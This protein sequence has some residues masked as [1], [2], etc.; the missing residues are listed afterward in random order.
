MASFKTINKLEKE[1]NERK[2]AKL[3]ERRQGLA[4]TLASEFEW[5]QKR[6][7]A[8]LANEKAEYQNRF[9][10]YYQDPDNEF[11]S[12]YLKKKSAEEK[13]LQQEKYE[14][15]KSILDEL[16]EHNSTKENI[17]NSLYGIT[18]NNPDRDS[19]NTRSKLEVMSQYKKMVKTFRYAIKSLE[20]EE[21]E[22]ARVVSRLQGMLQDKFVLTQNVEKVQ[23]SLTLVKNLSLMEND[24]KNPKSMANHFEDTM[25]KIQL[26][27]DKENVAKNL[28]LSEMEANLTRLQNERTE[29]L[30]HVIEIKIQVEDLSEELHRLMFINAKYDQE[31]DKFEGVVRHQRYL[32]EDAK[33][34]IYLSQYVDHKLNKLVTVNN[35]NIQPE[36]FV[37]KDPRRFISMEEL[38]Q[39]EDLQLSADELIINLPR[40]SW[41][42]PRTIDQ[43]KE[44]MD[45]LESKSVTGLVTRQFHNYFPFGTENLVTKTIQAYRFFRKADMVIKEQVESMT[46]NLKDKQ[47]M[48]ETLNK[49]LVERRKVEKNFSKYKGGRELGYMDH[50]EEL[51]N[52][53][54]VTQDGNLL[55]IHPH[56]IRKHKQKRLDSNMTEE[57]SALMQPVEA[58]IKQILES[59]R[60]VTVE[61]TERNQKKFVFLLSLLE[62]VKL[63][64]RRL[65]DLVQLVRFLWEKRFLRDP[66][67]FK[68]IDELL[69]RSMYY[70]RSDFKEDPKK[71]TQQLGLTHL[72]NSK[73]AGDV[74][75]S[76]LVVC[77]DEDAP[78]KVD[79]LRSYMENH[80]N[81]AD[82]YI[83]IREIECNEFV[84]VHTNLE[85][86][87]HSVR[88]E[89]DAIR[90]SDNFQANLKMVYMN[91]LAPEIFN[92]VMNC[93][94][95]NYCQKMSR[96]LKELEA[97]L[98]ELI[99][100]MRDMTETSITGKLKFSERDDPWKR[101]E[102]STPSYLQDFQMIKPYKKALDRFFNQDKLQT[103]QQAIEMSLLAKAYKSPEDSQDEKVPQLNVDDVKKMITTEKKKQIK[104]QKSNPNQG[105]KSTKAEVAAAP[106]NDSLWQLRDASNNEFK[107]IMGYGTT[108]RSVKKYLDKQAKDALHLLKIPSI[109]QANV[110]DRTVIQRLKTLMSQSKS[111]LSKSC[112]VV[113]IDS[114]HKPVTEESF[115]R[116][117]T[118]HH[119][120]TVTSQTDM[121]ITTTGKNIQPDTV[122]QSDRKVSFGMARVMSPDIGATPHHKNIVIKEKPN[123]KISQK[124]LSPRSMTQHSPDMLSPR[125]SYFIPQSFGLR[126]SSL[127]IL[128]RTTTAKSMQRQDTNSTA[129]LKDLE[130]DL[131]SYILSPF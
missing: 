116:R 41:T 122:M 94:C 15:V 14:T 1:E 25:F 131:D 24:L 105:T 95:K 45:E 16:K 21:M 31:L 87:R 100:S 74:P 108:L 58:S 112:K 65:F 33:S 7:D 70:K 44:A 27:I 73:Y 76:K 50:F 106:T 99:Y 125:Q 103:K 43:M 64:G 55:G 115:V 9:G 119:D 92:R 4:Q 104:P 34:L 127:R 90:R 46:L 102:T 51:I 130:Q 61:D 123:F 107:E 10:E 49:A 13:I 109:L 126:K 101:L 8:E 52:E 89:L 114:K 66:A 6:A 56:L 93:A 32:K 57:P 75:Q 118:E 71:P 60:G 63:L 47:L 3:E 5:I 62:Q 84:I 53:H 113:P 22:Q 40:W 12:V 39:G 69:T 19:V 111:E 48:V 110:T 120:T 97:L 59:Y 98:K 91:Q 81:I 17:F 72:G 85:E 88:V 35:P 23:R 83:V 37:K 80:F 11:E 129:K 42:H 30:K 18:S 117:H 82:D 26:D 28:V 67:P 77:K 79:Q 96:N 54:T 68:A 38:F 36:Q 124:Q 2:A 78:F 128:S 29:L 86:I 20:T 121:D